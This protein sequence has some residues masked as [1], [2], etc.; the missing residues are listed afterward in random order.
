MKKWAIYVGF[1]VVLLSV[2]YYFVYTQIDFSESGLPV[3]NNNIQSFSFTDQNGK[4]ITNRDVVGKVYV[5]NY[6]FTTCRGICPKMNANMRRV[7][8]Q[9]KNEKD[10]MIL[11]HTCM[12][13]VDSP[14][15]LKKYEYKMVNGTLSERTDG[16]YDIIAPTDSTLAVQNANWLFLTGDKASLYDLA[17]HSYLIDKGG[18]DT[19]LN[20]NEQFIHTQLF[21]LVD[22]QERVRGIYDGLKDDE[23]QKL[24]ADT[25]AL[26]REKAPKQNFLNN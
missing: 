21:A 15:I 23:I 18:S 6:F 7:F 26:L 4:N 20:I 25:K 12:P 13:E 3:I 16:S 19:S 10:F 5:A 24:I 17:R 22:K 2:F 1:F 14:A 8:D 9:F 11:S